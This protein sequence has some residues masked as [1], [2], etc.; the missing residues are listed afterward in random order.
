MSG[1]CV[2]RA[3]RELTV[4]VPDLPGSAAGA[5]MRILQ[6]YL[7]QSLARPVVLDFRPG[8]GGIVGLMAGARA[9]ADGATLTLLTPAVTL[10]PWLS[11]RM[12]CTPT[13]FAPL[14][15]VSFA[16]V[17]LAV[18]ADAPYAAVPDLLAG[19]TAQGEWAVPGPSDW[20]PSEVGQALFA[21]SAGLRVRAVGGL[22]T[23]AARAEAL[24]AGDVDLAFL[25][26]AQVLDPGS[27]TR[28]RVLGVTGP[29]RVPQLPTV[30][31]LREAGFDIAVGA[32][33]TL[34]VPVESPPSAVEELGGTLKAIMEDKRVRAELADARL[35]PAWLGP[36]E[37]GRAMDAEYREAGA[38]F[39]ALGLSVRKEVLGLGRG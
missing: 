8:A 14:G 13:D 29:A 18:R 22:N 6:P 12:D 28:L 11:R 34:A 37:T 5:A 20:D 38:L 16:P 23:P 26:L 3:E 25:P 10:A 31:S 4:I 27:A 19:R 36:V 21:A 15:R 33:R 2:A 32:W 1:A 7:E 24:L 35:A 17:A 30:P 39:T 9:A